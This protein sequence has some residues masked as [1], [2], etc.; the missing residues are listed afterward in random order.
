M[1]DTDT[2][3]QSGQKRN[4]A[5]LAIA[6]FSAFAIFGFTDSARG[7]AIPR[8]QADFDL[9]ELDL[10]VLLTGN[11]VGYLVSCTFTAALARKIG[12]KSCLITGLLIMPVSGVFMCLAQS[13]TTLAAA[14]FLLNLGFGMLEVSLGIIAAT[15]FTK[16]TGAMLNLAHFFY[17]VG[18]TISPLITTRI[19]AAR[20]GDGVLGWRYMYLII[21]SFALIP[22]IPALIGRLKKQDYNKKKTGYTIILK[23]PDFWFTVMIIAL[24]VICEIGIVAWLVNFLEKSY[25][26]SSEQAALRLTLFFVCFTL[27]RL[28]V[29]PIIDKVGLINALVIFTIFAGTMITAG[30]IC[31]EKGVF[32]L[33]IAGIGVAPV[34]PTVM[35]VI[36]K[37]Y[38]DEID[39]A[40][41]ATMTIMG[42]I[43]VPANLLLGGII[44]KAKLIFTDIH[45]EADVRKAY[46]VGFLFLGFCCVVAFVFALL[47]RRKQK[48]A[49][50][51]V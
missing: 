47:L 38:R 9:T 37:L 36:A 27:T 41:T 46:A 25:S 10:G 29:G 44:N 6:I 2:I 42:I 23:K 7:S 15:T 8:I 3:E 5:L 49:G 51:L 14:Y 26:F 22:A 50:Q 28:I 19:M 35:A 30:V 20:L 11:V 16:N 31:G 45:G 33:V 1:E 40:M 12:I 24:G 4:F 21:L 39:V 48:K 43:M 13:F 34:F 17:G 18:A 32:L